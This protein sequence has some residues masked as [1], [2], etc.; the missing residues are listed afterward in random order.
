LWYHNEDFG[1]LSVYVLQ[2]NFGPACA[3]PVAAFDYQLTGTELALN[4]TSVVSNE[5]TYL[6]DF[7]DGTTSAVENPTHEYVA[8]DLYNVC[9]T[10]TELCGTDTKCSEV[11]VSEVSIEENTRFSIIVFPNP[12]SS[13][14]E[15]EFENIEQLSVLQVLN[16]LGQIVYSVD[17]GKG[18]SNTILDVSQWSD[19]M[20]FVQTQNGIMQKLM[21]QH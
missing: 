10:I 9:L 16:S 1:F 4:N 7:G 8:N 20:Y 18:E 6:W 17:L 11:L 2:A 14:V 12:S 21:V 3:E 19:G 13:R 5:A 15:I